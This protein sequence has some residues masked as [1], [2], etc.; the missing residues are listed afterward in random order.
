MTKEITAYYKMLRLMF[1]LNKPNSKGVSIDIIT[2]LDGFHKHWK[3]Y[4]SKEFG[5]KIK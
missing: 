5:R 1:E 2:F 4:Y 3:K